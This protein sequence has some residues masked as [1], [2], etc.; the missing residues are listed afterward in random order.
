[1]IKNFLSALRK[2]KPL[3]LSITNEVT[4]NDCASAIVAIGAGAIMSSEVLEIED[5]VKISSSV[6]INIGTVNKESF[7]IMN[8]AAYCAK[9]Y[10]KS[11]VLDLVGLGASR[12]RNE[13]V[14]KL[15]KKSTFN[16][17]KGNVSEIKA[18]ICLEKNG[19]LEDSSGVDVRN[20]DKIEKLTDLKKTSIKDF[21]ISVKKLAE[22]L[23]C[24]IIITGAIDLIINKDEIY[25]VE[26]GHPMMSKVCGT[27]CILSGIMA[28]FLGI[29]F[30]CNEEDA[31]KC[32]IAAVCTYDIC[33]ELAFES[34]GKAYRPMAY[35]KSLIDFL[36]S[37]KDED[38]N[39]RAKYRPV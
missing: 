21:L 24:V 7:K 9:K 15:L 3:V 4:I 12:Y 19:I 11:S 26:N 20:D 33:G 14:K 2:T 22:R 37:I 35:K 13:V 28:A 25:A 29:N 6:N 27:G 8:I 31:K 36:Y 23:C 30:P 17:L 34:M 16:V 1:M 18:L 32:S 10:R 38:V 5:L 39:K